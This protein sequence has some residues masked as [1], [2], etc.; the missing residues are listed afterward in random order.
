MPGSAARARA[1][2]R[3][4][5]GAGHPAADTIDRCVTELVAN[6]VACTASGLPG[7]TVAV[8]VESTAAGSVTV[9]V[10]DDGAPHL[11][12]DPAGL[13]DHGRWLRLLTALA[14]D[15]GAAPDAAW[16]PG[17]LV[18]LRRGGGHVSAGELRAEERAR[19][20]LALLRA[21][22]SQLLA[23]ARAAGAAGQHAPDP[24]GL[25][26]GVLAASGQL[27]P[28]GMGPQQLLA[29]CRTGASR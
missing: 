24:P 8:V 3:A 10:R 19:Q 27:P 28:A 2:T 15:W 1:F 17:G 20:Q 21:E 25:I 9:T 12:G 5:L 16:R 11:I 6:A 18:P 14:D 23:A 7:A 29:V 22:H 13:A 26:R 4:A